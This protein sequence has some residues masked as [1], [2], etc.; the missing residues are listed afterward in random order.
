M[1]SDRIEFLCIT[2]K[3]LFFQVSLQKVKILFTD[4]LHPVF[5]IMFL[6][7]IQC[8]QRQLF[9]LHHFFPFHYFNTVIFHGAGIPDAFSLGLLFVLFYVFSDSYPIT[10]FD[11]LFFFFQGGFDRFRLI[12]SSSSLLFSAFFQLRSSA[13]FGKVRKLISTLV[14][15]KQ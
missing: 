15:V 5:K 10:C 7:F 11:A 4:H 6:L 14:C 8:I 12:F 9:G 2:I 1:V 13:S 3:L